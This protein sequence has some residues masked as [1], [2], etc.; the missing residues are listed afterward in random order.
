MKLWKSEPFRILNHNDC[1]IWNIYPDF[2]NSCRHKNIIFFVLELIHNFIFF[3]V[4]K[5]SVQEPDFIFRK[6]FILPLF[7]FYGRSFCRK[8]FT[9][10]NKGINYICLT[11]GLDFSTYQACNLPSWICHCRKYRFS[12]ARKLINNSQI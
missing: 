8:S 2:D 4:F 11:S 3:I 1:S 5:L 6:N 9:F 12:T 7:F 10:L